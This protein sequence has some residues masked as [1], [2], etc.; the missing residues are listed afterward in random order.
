MQGIFV[1]FLVCL[2]VW[3]FGDGELESYMF[4]I[5][6]DGNGL[7]CDFSYAKEDGFVKPSP[8]YVSI[9]ATRRWIA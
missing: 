8:I 9:E 1:D 2:L 7:Y 5:H 6:P 4:T 3:V